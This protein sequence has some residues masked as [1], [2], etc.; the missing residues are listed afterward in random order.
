MSWQKITAPVLIAASCAFAYYLSFVEAG[1]TPSFAFVVGFVFGFVMQKSRFCFYCHIRDY[2][3]DKNPNGVLALLLALAIGLIGY[4]IVVSSWLPTPAPN[5]L[6]P[7][8]HAG[9]VSEVLA[10]AGAVFGFGMVLS[11]SCVAAHWYHLSEGSI[12]SLIALCGVALGFFIGFNSW[13]A[14]YSFRIADSRIIW[15]PAY[16]GYSIALVLQLAILGAIAAFVWKFS[17]KPPRE[18]PKPLATFKEIYDRFF[19]QSWSYYVGGAIIGALGFLIIIWTK[20]LGVT[21]TIASWTRFFSGAYDL[22]PARLHGLDGFAGCGSLPANFWLNTD[23]LLLL[24]LVVGSFASSF[25]ANDF[26]LQKPTLKE[27]A[28]SFVGGVLLG[29]GAM[30][31]LGCTIGTLL[32]GIHAGALSGWVFALGMILAIWSALKIKNKFIA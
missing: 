25:A 2:I 6:P 7:D 16:F 9:P 22:I 28:L 11:K 4:T 5:N 14:L 26:E 31:A 15:L 18:S 23:A 24:G 30:I 19:A 17:L 12:G 8:I 21:A 3:E 10:L 27:S 1:R 32:S 13:N 29:F 20:P